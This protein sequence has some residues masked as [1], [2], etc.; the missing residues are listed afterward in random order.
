MNETLNKL[1]TWGATCGLHFNSSKTVLLHFINNCKRNRIEPKIQISRQT[2]IPSKHTRYMGV[3]IDDELNWD[4][5]ITTKIDKY[6]NLFAILSANVRHTFGPKPKLS[7]WVYTGVIRP[8]LLYACQAW[9]DK[10]SDKH[11]KNELARQ[12]NYNCHGTKPIPAEVKRDLH[13]VSAAV[14]T[15][16][17][18]I[19][20]KP[21]E[22][23]E[24]RGQVL[25]ME[26]MDLDLGIANNNTQMILTACSNKQ[27]DRIGCK[28]L[29]SILLPFFAGE[30]EPLIE[31]P[32]ES[33]LQRID[34]KDLLPPPSNAPVPADFQFDASMPKYVREQKIEFLL[35]QK[36]AGTEQA[37]AFPNEENLHRIWTYVRNKLDSDYILD[38]C[39]WPR[40]DKTTGI[41][42]IMLSTVD[43]Q[44]MAQ[45]RHEI[46][47]Y[48]EIEGLRFE[49]YCK[50]LFI[51]RYGISMY[52]PKEHA[53]LSSQRILRALFYKQRD[54]YT[55]NVRLL[56][57]H[58]FKANAPGFQL[59]QRSRVG[60]AILLFD[61][62]ELAAKLKIYDVEHRFLVSKGFS[63]TFR[64]YER[65]GT[66]EF[67]PRDDIYSY[68][69]RRRSGNEERSERTRAGVE[70]LPMC[71]GGSARVTNKCNCDKCKL[72]S[73][74]ATEIL[75]KIL[76]I[77]FI[78]FTCTSKL[79][80][81][82]NKERRQIRN[83]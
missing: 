51:K 16:G 57:K 13:G 22:N 79:R 24:R 15:A 2:V 27:I 37:C 65:R 72:I 11:I 46:R 40:L 80:L 36:P 34:F 10:M 73:N 83:K 35:V 33:S 67:F 14:I 1:V 55:R 69:Q 81:K 45:V 12:T 38:V 6:R 19:S 42:S 77:G 8:K 44:V 75:F 82:T 56:S 32:E 74:Q 43:L 60:D 54:L 62:P 39:L 21:Q 70:L 61:S 52:V 50:T 64:G 7:K 25:E 17:G 3:E 59:G 49:T 28:N 31:R 30:L 47:I 76:H 41:A 5:H 23:R 9:A 63:V 53:G 4:Y 71:E 68:C 29:W 78:M 20:N 66:S 58:R 26:N 18:L 48:E